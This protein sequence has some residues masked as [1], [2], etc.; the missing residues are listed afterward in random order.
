MRA[1][2][3][4]LWSEAKAECYRILT[5]IESA[6]THWETGPGTLRRFALAVLIQ[7]GSPRAVEALGKV[8]LSED[9][10][11]RRRAVQTIGLV[12]DEGA[13]EVLARACAAETEPVDIVRRAA[14]E[15]VGYIDGARSFELLLRVLRDDEAM[16]QHAALRSLS[17][18]PRAS[19]SIEALCELLGDEDASSE[20]RLHAAVALG[21]IGAQGATGDLLAVAENEREPA[22]LR[23][24]CIKALSWLGFDAVAPP[25]EKLVGAEQRCLQLASAEAL[26]RLQWSGSLDAIEDVVARA[27][28]DERAALT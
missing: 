15:A 2:D 19:V 7:L 20:A 10:Y 25:A 4:E 23:S 22:E 3:P 9:R 8:L 6:D 5:E 24:W 27:D 11:L 26:C 13:C 28:E 21:E 12:G 17:A 14:S 16:V 18:L 1:E